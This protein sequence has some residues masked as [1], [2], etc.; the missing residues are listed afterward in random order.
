MN[1]PAAAAR[2]AVRVAR[3]RLLSNR[4]GHFWFTQALVLTMIAAIYLTDLGR[5]SSPD[6]D[7]ARFFAALHVA[8][9]AFGV[10]P[11]LYATL[12]CGL[13]GAIL[14]TLWVVVL[15][16]LTL[17]LRGPQDLNGL[18][19]PTMFVTVL[20][21]GTIL[22]LRV[23]SEREARERAEALSVRLSLLH[24]VMQVLTQHLPLPALLESLVDT[25]RR[26]MSTDY[27]SIRYQAGDGHVIEVESG[28][29]ALA[30]RS[31]VSPHRRR[32]GT[33]ADPVL[34]RC[35]V[36][37]IGE[38]SSFGVLG[39][40]RRG[41]LL[42]SDERQ[43]LAIAGLEASAAF[44]VHLLQ[45]HRREALEMYARQV[46]N[47]QEAERARIAR[48]LHDGP[49]QLLVGLVRAADLIEKAHES[50][51]ASF[52]AAIERLREVSEAAL[53]ELRAATRDLRPATLHHLGL[54]SALRSLAAEMS[55][56]TGIAVELQF[57]E[58]VPLREEVELCIFRI[59]QEALMNVEKHAHA[60]HV[61]ADIRRA[62]GE[63]RVEVRDNG[64]GAAL[65]AEP[66][67]FA[68]RGRFGVLGMHERA[69]LIEGTLE[70]SSREGG[71]SVLLRIPLGS[72]EP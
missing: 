68:H 38:H 57:D 43:I 69:A 8:A 9:I 59:V 1:I 62:R 2:Q 13:E 31:T 49:V 66:S 37:L 71:T 14:T 26:G 65:P 55:E 53:T 42:S 20:A 54:P 5:T 32:W 56:R 18:V 29:R 40:A 48:D 46:T 64:H 4:S 21:I 24:E 10:V 27:A 41:R 30:E 47:A 70:I 6:P 58:G 45:D 12:T 3:P 52:N 50:D 51:A 33:G 7:A 25:V 19:V 34:D 15:A 60:T 44:E 11:V 72:T 39:V 16:G 35:V 23:E 22:A 61:R 17:L 36:P 63:L 67:E 28:D